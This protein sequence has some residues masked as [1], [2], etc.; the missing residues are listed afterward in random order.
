MLP[1][2]V[3]FQRRKNFPRATTA[4]AHARLTQTNPYTTQADPSTTSSICMSAPTM[5]YI[6][7]IQMWNGGRGDQWNTARS[8][9]MGMAY[10]TRGDMPY[11]HA[12]ADTFTIGDQYFQSTFTQTN[13]NRLHHFSGSNGLS[14][15]QTPFLDNA[16]PNPGHTWITMAEVL[17]EA[18]IS[19]KTY[20]QEDN[21]DDNANAWFASFQKAKPGDPLVSFHRK[22]LRTKTAPQ[23]RLHPLPTVRQGHK[24][25]I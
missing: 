18:G 10:F 19:W 8:P 3:R 25:H 11:Y 7:D 6:T 20:Q 5:N 24:V 2:H 1:W 4:R 23:R 15:N 16:E 13:P 22:T 9:G 12:L 21:F 14:V 17:E